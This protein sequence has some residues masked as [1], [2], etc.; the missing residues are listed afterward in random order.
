MT[1]TTRALTS[2]LASL[3][4]VPP[5]RHGP[6]CTVGA[7]LDSLDEQAADSLRHVLDQPQVTSTLI[8][9]TL[10]ANGKP[11]QAPAVARHRRRGASNGCRCPR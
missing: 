9:D 6:Q 7:I 2:A 4:D 3:V 11:I 8:A 1:D 10:T 5:A